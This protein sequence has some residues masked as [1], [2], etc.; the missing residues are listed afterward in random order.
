MQPIIITLNQTVLLPVEIWL[1][2][3]KLNTKASNEPKKPMP[4]TSH[5]KKLPFLPILNARG[6]SFMI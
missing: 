6:A 5:I 3:M 2:G 4:P 1:G